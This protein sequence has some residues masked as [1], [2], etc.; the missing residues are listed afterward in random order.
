MN[1]LHKC[2]I[3]VVKFLWSV[4]KLLSLGLVHN[5][6]QIEHTRHTCPPNIALYTVYQGHLPSIHCWTILLPIHWR[7]ARLFSYYAFA[8]LPSR[9][10]PAHCWQPLMFSNGAGM[11]SMAQT[12][13]ICAQDLFHLGVSLT[14]L[15]VLGVCVKPNFKGI[16]EHRRASKGHI[17]VPHPSHQERLIAPMKQRWPAT[18]AHHRARVSSRNAPAAGAPHRCRCGCLEERERERERERVSTLGIREPKCW[19]LAISETECFAP[20]FEV[21]LSRG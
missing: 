15:R 3:C 11:G 19:G 17:P 21:F 14:C 20:D 12:H 16:R 18:I 1:V 5:F 7:F 2:E 9:R 8:Q 6:K 13:Q 10:L 4:Y